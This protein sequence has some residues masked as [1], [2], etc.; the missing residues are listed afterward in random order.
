MA[1]KLIC[2]AKTSSGC[3]A[4]ATKT[5]AE[6][7]ARAPV[8]SESTDSHGDGD[9]DS[10]SKQYEMVMRSEQDVRQKKGKRQGKAYVRVSAELRSP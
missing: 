1:K 8:A 2:K 4:D 7:A 10:V 5:L 9:S 3:E 6:Q